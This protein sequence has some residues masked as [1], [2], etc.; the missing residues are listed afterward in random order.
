[1]CYTIYMKKMYIIGFLV[2][3][4]LI[5]GCEGSFDIAKDATIDIKPINQARV[6]VIKKDISEYCFELDQLQLGMD[7][8]IRQPIGYVNDNSHVS[9]AIN[10]VYWGA[11]D[12]LPQGV[13]YIDGKDYSSGKGLISGY[14]TISRDRSTVAVSETLAGNRQNY[15]IILGTHPILVSDGSVHEQAT[16]DRYNVSEQGDKVSFRSAIGTKSGSDICFAVSNGLVTMKQWA[17]ELV[18]Q[19]YTNAMNLDGG[20]VS[21]LGVRHDSGT[22]VYGGGFEDTR[23]IIYAQDL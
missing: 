9:A 11:D 12:G 5:S 18:K 3:A 17:S 8:V 7:K 10:G 4:L 16:Q 14:F 22:S 23:L 15:H 21:Q 6:D 20:S 2:C 19:G 1:M 13:A